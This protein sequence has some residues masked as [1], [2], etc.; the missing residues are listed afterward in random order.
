MC[1]VYV[2][3]ETKKNIAKLER[4]R[5][6]ALAEAKKKQLE[7]LHAKHN[8]EAAGSDVVRREHYPYAHAS[9]YVKASARFGGTT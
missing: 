3:D 7:A 9:N 6:K 8:K 5:L 1:G 4:Q 2:Q